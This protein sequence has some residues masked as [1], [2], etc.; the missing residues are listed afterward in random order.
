[1]NETYLSE[2]PVLGSLFGML[3]PDANASHIMLFLL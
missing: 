2:L 1:M 3:D